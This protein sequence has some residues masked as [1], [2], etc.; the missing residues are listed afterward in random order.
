MKR[1]QKRFEDIMSAVT[2]AEE[3]EFDTAKEFL[4]E[5]RKV[6]YAVKEGQDDSRAFRYAMNVCSRIGASLDILY[7]SP[8][9]IV[10]PF[11]DQFVIELKK[12]G[13]RHS[14]FH[15]SGCL[16]NQ[17]IDH[18]DKKKGILFVIVGSSENLAVDCRRK[19]KKLSDAWDNLGCPLVVVSDLETA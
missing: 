17:I 19:N 1:L 3:G 14:L 12:E 9:K 10:S 2:F 18:T 13:I 11:I 4:N 5:G 16:K 6:L 7:V 15:T 8:K